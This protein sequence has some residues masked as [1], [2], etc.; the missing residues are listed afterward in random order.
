MRYVFN[1]YWIFLTRFENPPVAVLKDLIGG[2]KREIPQYHKNRY[3]KEIVSVKRK[4]MDRAAYCLPPKLIIII[5]R[6][7]MKIRRIVKL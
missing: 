7:L 4:I 2:L 5:Y 6:F 3:Y 1:S